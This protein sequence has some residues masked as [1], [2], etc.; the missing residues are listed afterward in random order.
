MAYVAI[1]RV[2]LRKH[3]GRNCL[4]SHFHSFCAC[5]YTRCLPI[6]G[7]ND[8]LFALYESILKRITWRKFFFFYLILKKISKLTRLNSKL[9]SSSH[10]YQDWTFI[11][12]VHG[13]ILGT[14]VVP[15]TSKY[16]RQKYISNPA[17]VLLLVINLVS[18]NPK[19]QKSKN[20]EQKIVVVRVPCFVKKE[21]YHAR[22][23]NGK[24]K[25]VNQSINQL[26]AC[27]EKDAIYSVFGSHW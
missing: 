14:S 11:S 6:R 22:R 16:T 27:R 8:H 4:T 7:E 17:P 26:V 24:C 21:F 25:S 5:A 9:P 19:K 23:K 15:S 3:W 20:N 12:D 2:T 18:Q 13:L 1:S 10:S